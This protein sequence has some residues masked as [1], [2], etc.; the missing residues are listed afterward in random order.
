MQGTADGGRWSVNR[1]D[2]FSGSRP[3]KGIGGVLVPCLD[4]LGFNIFE[5]GLLRDTGHRS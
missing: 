1:K 4:P 3:I 2:I 5:G